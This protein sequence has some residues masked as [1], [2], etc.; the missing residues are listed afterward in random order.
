MASNDSA[1]SLDVQQQSPFIE[2]KVDSE[3]AGRYHG[4]GDVLLA[5]A[6][7]FFP[8]VALT[9]ALILVITMNRYYPSD[10]DPYEVGTFNDAF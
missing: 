7:V 4:L 1:A 10:S 2:P 6:L 3:S 8:F 5:T 9:V